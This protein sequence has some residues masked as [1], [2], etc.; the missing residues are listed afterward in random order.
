MATRCAEWHFD[1]NV[2][3]LPMRFFTPPEQ[4]P[5]IVGVPIPYP[6]MVDAP[7]RGAVLFFDEADALFANRTE[8][9][10]G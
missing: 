8:V 4:P 3:T 10:S 2:W 7:P 9:K 1:Y 6:N 5:I